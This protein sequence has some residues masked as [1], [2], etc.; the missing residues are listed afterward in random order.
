[1][2][3]ISINDTGTRILFPPLLITCL[4]DQN[5]IAENDVQQR[6]LILTSVEFQGLGLTETDT[7]FVSE[8]DSL[9]SLIVIYPLLP[10]FSYFKYIASS[11]IEI[12]SCRE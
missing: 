1:M 9:S 4:E 6:Y 12:F 5:T 10:N 2:C 7:I 11:S 8:H 3:T